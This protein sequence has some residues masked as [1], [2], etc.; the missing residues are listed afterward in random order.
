MMA[1]KRP[2][3]LDPIEHE[4]EIALAPGRFIPDR[5]CFSFVDGLDAAETKIAELIRSDPNR[6]IALYDV[7]LA[8]CYEKA[9]EVDDSSGSFGDFVLELF[10]G[11]IKA[12]QAAKADSNNTAALLLARMDDDP[13]GFCYRADV[14]AV[15]VFDKA[16]L[17]AFEKL[18][19]ARFDAAIAN[20][21]APAG[22]REDN[23]EYSRRRWGESLRT[24]YVAQKNVQAYTA[25]AGEDGITVKDCHAVATLIS[26]QHK[27]GEAL[28]WVDRGIELEKNANRFDTVG[29]ELYKLKRELLAK[30]GRGDEALDGAWTEYVKRPSE[31]S[32]DDL[33]KCVPKPERSTWHTK[34]I[35]AAQ[36][37][38]IHSLMGLLLK[39]KE[40]ERLAEFVRQSNAA[41][42]E[43]LSHY[44]TEPVAKK[45]EKSHP[46][47]AARLWC[48]QGMRIV[49]GKK[50]KYYDAALANFKRAKRCF[51]K[52]GL[53]CEWQKTVAHVQAEHHR[54]IG[55]MAG[56][57]EIAAG[58]GKSAQPS[59]LERAKA[60]W[61][62]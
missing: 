21:P 27:H 11:W 37:A 19:R 29:Y 51:E 44:T 13:Y 4:I 43:G 14:D 42:I 32:Y 46:D 28:K 61:K 25:L 50:S 47:A 17:A 52:A 7:F 57:K 12:R 56:F 3:K 22:S 10:S 18:I 55:F 31:H 20:K 24:I 62:N 8:G 15:Q 23:P 30:L 40:I 5:G 9:D 58:R 1:S 60:K 48:A 6:A 16:G 35:D 45:L 39:T 36:G 26:G 59:F 53:D 2:C 49:N 38:D 33:M 34:A 41:A 54:K